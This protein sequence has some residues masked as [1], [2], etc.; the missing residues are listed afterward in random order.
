MSRAEDHSRKLG[1]PRAAQGVGGEDPRAEILDAAAALFT[2]VGYTRTTTRQ[3]AEAVGLRQGSLFHYFSRKQDILEELLNSTI[4]PAIATATWLETIEAPPEVKLFLLV[5]QDA[6]NLCSLPHNLGS[7][8]F[9]PEIKS[10]DFASLWEN[11]DKLRGMYLHLIEE[12]QAAGSFEVETPN[13]ATDLVFGLVESVCTWYRTG[14]RSPADVGRAVAKAALQTLL[15]SSASVTR[16]E[17]LA[18]AQSGLSPVA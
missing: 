18:E 8:Y 14:E 9:Q 13:E 7:L 1:R 16:I 12:A 17:G 5:E 10:D 3:I 4:E 2:K 6:T 15:P 11:R